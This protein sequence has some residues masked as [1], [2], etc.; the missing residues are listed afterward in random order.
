MKQYLKSRNP[1]A[2][3]S[4]KRAKELPT[5]LPPHPIF[6]TVREIDTLHYICPLSRWSICYYR[7]REK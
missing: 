4:V 5:L 3:E 7:T 6:G 2:P 1:P